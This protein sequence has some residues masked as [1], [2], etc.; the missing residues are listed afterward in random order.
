MNP[1]HFFFKKHEIIKPDN[2]EIDK[3]IHDMYFDC[4]NKFF[5]LFKSH[6]LCDIEF[7]NIRKEK[8]VNK[9][10]RNDYYHEIIRK[11]IKNLYLFDETFSNL[12]K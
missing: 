2:N 7:A 11:H 4:E 12:F 9:K 3:D 1:L 6:Y 8:L 5:H 10:I